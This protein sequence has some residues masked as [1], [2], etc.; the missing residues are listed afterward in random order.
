MNAPEM[1]R[2][3]RYERKRYRSL[4]QR[5]VNY[6]ESRIIEA[7]L[8]VLCWPSDSVLDMPCGYGR[9]V[10]ALRSRAGTVVCGDRKAAML[11]RTR[12]RMGDQTSGVRLLSDGLP[13][14]DGSFDAV[15]CIRL[16]QHL[17]D[18]DQRQRTLAEIGRVA[19]R[20]AVITVYLDSPVHRLIH[21]ARRLKRLTRDRMD[22]LEHQL[23]Q[24]GLRI[25]RHSRILP[26][27]HAQTIL[28]LERTA[29]A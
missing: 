1:T 14:S 28:L 21:G 8:D 24:C 7:Y 10:P 3:R 2:V 25:R 4:D 11:T 27:L 29:P 26:A 17:H 5:L 9:F 12:E 18:N 22:R 13:F 19:R 6:L 20:G 16:F 23:G 15:T